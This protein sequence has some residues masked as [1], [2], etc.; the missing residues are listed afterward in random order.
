MA[1]L[2]P[3]NVAVVLPYP[4]HTILIVSSTTTSACFVEEETAMAT[5]LAFARNGNER[6]FV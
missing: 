2:L 3:D 5:E 1:H 6:D 4:R